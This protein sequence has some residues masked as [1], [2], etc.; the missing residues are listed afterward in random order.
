MNQ[1]P[2]SLQTAAMKPSRSMPRGGLRVLQ[3]S[4]CHVYADPDGRL[5]GLN[6]QNTFD[7]VLELARTCLGPPDLVLATG[8]LVHDAS[9]AGY[10]RL[11]ARFEALGAPV[12]CL[13]GNHDRPETMAECMRAGR[14]SAPKSL[15]CNDWLILLLDSTIPGQEGGHLDESDLEIL[16]QG[17]RDHP[18]NHALICLHHHPVPVGS[19]WMDTMALNNPDDFFRLLDRFP[20]VRGV[21]WGHIHQVFDQ[22]RNGVRLMGSPS[23]CIQFTPDK[24]TFCIDPAA[25]GLRWL[26]LLPDGTIRSGVER[27]ADT[28]VELNTRLRGY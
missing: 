17:L 25:P 4:D 5:G 24:D 8:D 10:E 3:I 7:E 27:L 6:T 26:E 22:V 14:V 16:E 1:K 9:V 18:D 28:P 23:T 13:P 21:L 2:V 11:R 19:A 15:V 20:K 12:Y